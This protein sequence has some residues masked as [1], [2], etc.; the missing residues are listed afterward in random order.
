MKYLPPFEVLKGMMNLTTARGTTRVD[1]TYED[2]QQ[3]I[4][5]LLTSIEVDEDYYLLRNQDVA[6]GI[7]VGNIRSARE[8]FVDH[9]YF[10]G[11]LPYRIEVDETWYLTTHADVAETVRHGYFELRP[12]PFRWPRLSGRAPTLLHQAIT[13]TTLITLSLQVYSTNTFLA[14]ASAC[15]LSR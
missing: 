9:G 12:G 8:H 15:F 6:D 1:M 11:R 13:T 3:L 10:E 2:I 5:A 7:R 4:R 14:A